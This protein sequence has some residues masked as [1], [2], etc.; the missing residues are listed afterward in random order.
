M[1]ILY[2]VN[3]AGFFCSHRLPI[4]LA[5]QR[6]GHEVALLT[7]QAGSAIIESHA[8]GQ[9]RAHA[10]AHRTVSFRSAGKAPIAECL[11]LLQTILFMLRWKPDLVHCASPKGVL[12][13]GIAARLTARH[14]LVLAVTGMGSMFVGDGSGLFGLA[15]KTYLWMAK[16]AF[17]H[18]RCLTIV[19]NQDDLALLVAHNLAEPDGSLLIPGSGVALDQFANMDPSVRADLVV[20]PARLL[21]DK[22]VFEF[23]EAARQI[24]ASGCQWRFAL[25][26]TTDYQN[27]TSVQAAQVQAWV[28]EGVIEWW[29]HREDMVSVYAQAGIVCLP[30]YREGM[31]K[32]LLEAAAAGCPVVTTNAVGCRDAIQPGRSGDL[33]AVGDAKALAVTLQALI[34]DAPRRLA[35]G[36]AGRQLAAERYSL[37]SVIAAT[38]SAYARLLGG[39][40][41]VAPG[42]VSGP[43]VRGSQS[44]VSQK[45]HPTLP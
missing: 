38:L 22:G 1:R 29:G 37:E 42:P 17:G 5:A 43:A 34:D 18:P 36:A 31:P 2:L 33:V 41:T 16:F 27:P 30:S 23:V 6:A 40:S 9:L 8:L 13:G 45:T 21:R 44:S 39:S 12:Y 28:D 26:G 10:I 25:V 35:Y 11:G 19:Q 3:N 15:R 4:A 24:R 7:G 20:L 14:A 32:A